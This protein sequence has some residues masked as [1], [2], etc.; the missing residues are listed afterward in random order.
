MALTNVICKYL[1]V[2]GVEFTTT[3]INSYYTLEAKGRRDPVSYSYHAKNDV[4]HGKNEVP[5][6]TR[7][8]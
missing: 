3:N 1:T 7:A 4:Y 8:L 6:M 2:E 5:Q